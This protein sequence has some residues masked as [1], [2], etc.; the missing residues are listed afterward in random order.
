MPV[1]HFSHWP[2]LPNCCYWSSLKLPEIVP[3]DRQILTSRIPTLAVLP[4]DPQTSKHREP[5]FHSRVWWL[6]PRV[7]EFWDKVRRTI[8]SL[9]VKK[10]NKQTKNK[11]KTSTTTTTKNGNQHSEPAFH[12]RVWWLFPLMRGF[13]DKVRRTISSLRVKNINNHG[14]H[15]EHTISLVRAGSVHRGSRTEKTVD[16]C[17]LKSWV[18]DRFPDRF[19]HYPRTA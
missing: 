18:S 15:L 19:Q 8:S 6:F 10:T 5:A 2:F 14:D 16:E 17:S 9:R 11:T 3:N 1:A 4:T 7:R 12:I 13:W